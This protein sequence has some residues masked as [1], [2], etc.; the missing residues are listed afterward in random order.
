MPTEMTAYP[1]AVT[2]GVFEEDPCV[3][4][5]IRNG[6]K[7]KDG[8]PSPRT[9]HIYDTYDTP[10]KAR[11]VATANGRAQYIPAKGDA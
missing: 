10:E 11:A 9:R 1:Y 2:W 5:W 4:Y 8:K 6:K 3:V 7:R